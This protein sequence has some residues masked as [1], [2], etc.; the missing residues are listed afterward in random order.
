MSGEGDGPR[1]QITA[2]GADGTRFEYFALCGPDY[3]PG[4]TGW[5]L[6]LSGTPEPSRHK[7]LALLTWPATLNR[8]VSSPRVR[9]SRCSPSR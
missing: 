1:A 2:L 6:V 5:V 3:S 9:A 8:C 4:E 7:P